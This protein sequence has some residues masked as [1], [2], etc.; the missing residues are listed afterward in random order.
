MILYAFPWF[1]FDFLWFSYDSIWFYI[2]LWFL[3][4]LYGFYM[5]F[6]W[7]IMIVG[8]KIHIGKKAGHSKIW[9]ERKYS[10]KAL[11]SGKTIILKKDGTFEKL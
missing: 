6:I 4:D 11:K 2:V 9:E 10:G 8:N 5:V 1:S 3:Y 7:F